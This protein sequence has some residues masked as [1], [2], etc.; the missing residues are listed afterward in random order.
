MKKIIKKWGDSLVL[1]FSKEDCLT[2]GLQEGSIV[3]LSDM[4]VENKIITKKGTKMKFLR[5]KAK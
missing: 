2:W 4:I 3:N 1:T 5:R